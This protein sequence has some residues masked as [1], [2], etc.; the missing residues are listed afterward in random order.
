MKFLIG[1]LREDIHSSIVQLLDRLCFIPR[2]FSSRI[3]VF[4]NIG[5]TKQSTS[6][7]LR[8]YHG[9]MRNRSLPMLSLLETFLC[10]SVAIYF[11]KFLNSHPPSVL[12]KIII[13][14]YRGITRTITN[15][16]LE[17]DRQY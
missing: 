13:R 17:K 2:N 14:I 5:E 11:L 10:I 6:R 12:V 7:I 8:N 9:L 15:Y 4:M 3:D 1:K 16:D